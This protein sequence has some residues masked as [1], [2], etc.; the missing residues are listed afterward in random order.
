MIDPR[1]VLSYIVLVCRVCMY[2]RV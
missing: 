2:A 1:L